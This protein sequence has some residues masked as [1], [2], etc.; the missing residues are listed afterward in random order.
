MEGFLGGVAGAVVGQGV[1][2][3][4]AYLLLATARRLTKKSDVAILAAIAGGILVGRVLMLLG[5]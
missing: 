5:F 3:A 2:F 1:A 4:V